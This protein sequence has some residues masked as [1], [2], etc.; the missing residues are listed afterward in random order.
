MK[1]E[2]APSCERLVVIIGLIVGLAVFITQGGREQ[3]LVLWNALEMAEVASGQEMK[4][5]LAPTDL[6]ASAKALDA[7][8]YDDK[9]D[10]IQTQLMKD[11]REAAAIML[12]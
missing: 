12:L 11:K 6:E 3:P 4:I 7:E 1:G 2:E 8:A 10:E 9:A 5:S